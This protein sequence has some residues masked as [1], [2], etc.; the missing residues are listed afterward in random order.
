MTRS[1]PL[2]L[3]IVLLAVST[4]LRVGPAGAA[5]I[6]ASIEF[7]AVPRPP[8]LPDDMQPLPGARLSF[9][10]IKAIDGYKVAAAL[11]QPDKKAPDATMLVQIHGSGS[12]LAELP[13]R[14]VARALSA[15][16]Y[17]ALTIS[18]RG[19]DENLNHD[20]FYDIRKDIEA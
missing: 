6:A 12:N 1:P 20:N 8:G 3:A 11:W 19:H 10:S 5:Q 9:L 7:D 17:G 14:S 15:K 13:L 2:W 18:T 4:A 16:G